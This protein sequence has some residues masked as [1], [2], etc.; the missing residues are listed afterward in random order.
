MLSLAHFIPIKLP[1]VKK[2]MRSRNK[3]TS[4]TRHQEAYNLDINS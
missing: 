3:F 4:Q 1:V 2:L